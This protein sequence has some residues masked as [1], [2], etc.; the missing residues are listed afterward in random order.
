[1]VRPLLRHPVI[2][3]RSCAIGWS[4]TSTGT[5]SVDPNNPNGLVDGVTFSKTLRDEKE[6]LKSR[7]LRDRRAQSSSPGTHS[8]IMWVIRAAHIEKP[9]DINSN[10]R[11]RD[12][13]RLPPTTTRRR[14]NWPTLCRKWREPV[15][16]SRLSAHRDEQSD[17]TLG[18]PRVGH[19]R[20]PGRFPPTFT[21]CAG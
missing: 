10:F 14:P 15:R 20:Q 16:S 7:V 21:Q 17:A 1:M 8:T 2:P 18:R 9:Y 4:T 13:R 6:Y 11:Q 3:R 12:R 5:P 19:R